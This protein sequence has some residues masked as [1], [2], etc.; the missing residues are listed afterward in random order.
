MRRVVL[1]SPY[2]GDVEA[3]VAYA[4]RC[5]LDSLSRGEAPIASHLLFP[6]ILSDSVAEERQLGMAAGHA[7][8][9]G[10]EAAVVYIDFGISKGML[11]GMM[12]AAAAGVPTEMRQIGG[13]S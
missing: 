3:H 8:Y 12:A 6:G 9:E 13:V 10:A 2:S 7:W 5:V 11:L 4:R 1:E